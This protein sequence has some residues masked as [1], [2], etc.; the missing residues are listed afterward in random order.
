MSRSAPSGDGAWCDRL[1]AVPMPT[2]LYHATTAKKYARMVATGSI[3]PPVRG[4]TTEAGA[5][6]WANEIHGTRPILLRLAL[7]GPAYPLP[8]HHNEHGWAF[9]SPAPARVQRLI[10]AVDERGDEVDLYVEKMGL[11][12]AGGFMREFRPECACL[13]AFAYAPTEA[14]L[15]DLLTRPPLPLRLVDRPASS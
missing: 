4:F 6:M 8:D 7:T 9:W 1:L 10:R 3:L 12:L 15:F 14:G 5:R 13:P 2:V 11:W